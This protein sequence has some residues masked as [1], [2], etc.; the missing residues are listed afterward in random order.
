MADTPPKQS[1]SPLDLCI[2]TRHKTPLLR[3]QVSGWNELDPF[4]AKFIFESTQKRLR[5]DDNSC[6][7]HTGRLKRLPRYRRFRLRRVQVHMPR[8]ALDW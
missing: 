7:L 3:R 6:I 1:P 4:L 2:A 5:M 8:R